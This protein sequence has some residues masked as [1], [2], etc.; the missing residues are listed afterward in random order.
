M[1]GATLGGGGVYQQ[2]NGKGP[3]I[4]IFIGKCFDD[5]LRR[6]IGR[7]VDDFAKPR[8][9]QSFIKTNYAKIRTGL[10][11]GPAAPE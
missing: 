8:V 6:A 3:D 10:V 9:S 4:C 1:S 11:E 5:Q 2:A 7:E